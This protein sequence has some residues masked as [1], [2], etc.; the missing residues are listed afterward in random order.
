MREQTL[1]ACPR[2]SPHRLIAMVAMTKYWRGILHLY[3]KYIVHFSI[4]NYCDFSHIN[5][6][7]KTRIFFQ[8]KTSE[9]SS[10]AF[11]LKVG[12]EPWPVKK[13]V[14]KDVEAFK[15]RASNLLC[16]CS[17]PLFSHV[18]LGIVRFHRSCCHTFPS[19]DKSLLV[20]R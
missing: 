7:A 4:T 19:F 13:P 11:T 3:K 14:K 15:K 5:R 18:S 17:F 10:T 20:K 8:K 9:S 1:V 2:P 16:P 12:A 6:L